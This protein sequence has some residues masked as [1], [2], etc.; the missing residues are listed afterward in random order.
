MV[1]ITSVPPDSVLLT[2]RG[3]SVQL[4]IRKAS[5]MKAILFMTDKV[6]RSAPPGSQ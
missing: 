5:A 1:A 2:P 3:L 6:A 4:P